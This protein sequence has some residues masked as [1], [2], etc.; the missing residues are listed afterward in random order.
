MAMVLAGTT[1]SVVLS[2]VAAIATATAKRVGCVPLLAVVVVPTCATQAVEWLVL[3]IV[4]LRNSARI[5]SIANQ[6]QLE[7]VSSSS[8]RSVESDT[9]HGMKAIISCLTRLWCLVKKCPIKVVDKS[10]NASIHL[11]TKLQVLDCT[12]SKESD[13]CWLGRNKNSLFWLWPRSD[14]VV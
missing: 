14:R 12:V 7:S 3:V 11:F 4:A 10:M 6:L 5:A 2:L 13:L 1:H 8:H 9:T